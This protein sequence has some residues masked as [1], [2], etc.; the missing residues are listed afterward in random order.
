MATKQEI[1]NIK[2]NIERSIQGLRTKPQE[3]IYEE[4]GGFVKPNTLY[5]ILYYR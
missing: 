4:A 3:F 1:Q 5:S 2:R